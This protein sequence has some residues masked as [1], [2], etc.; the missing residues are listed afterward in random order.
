MENQQTNS[1]FLGWKQPILNST[2]L[3]HIF[4]DDKRCKALYKEI[5][6]KANNQENCVV[7]LGIKTVALKRGQTL[8]GRHVFAK[9]LCWDDKTTDRALRKLE[10]VYKLVTNQRNNNYT[11]ISIHYYESVVGMTNQLTNQRPTNDQPVTTSKSDKNEKIDNT[12]NVEDK[13]VFGSPDISHLIEFMKKTM[14]IPTLDGT[15]KDNR[16]SAQRLIRSHKELS[17]IEA[18]IEMAAGDPWMKRNYTKLSD[19]ERNWV[20]IHNQIKNKG[21]LNYKESNN[22][23]N[24]SKF[25]KHIEGGD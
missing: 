9:E 16:F 15:T 23:P 3:D 13:K 8:Y 6:Y 24:K 11:V 7:K 25:L 12:T 5:I 4:G 19:I 22:D 21:V 1:L 2:D 20:K 18:T 14:E 17:A 10:K